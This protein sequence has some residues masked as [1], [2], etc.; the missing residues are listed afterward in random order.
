MI[1]VTMSW[2]TDN[3]Q[4]T[5]GFAEKMRII[6]KCDNGANQTMDHRRQATL[7]IIIGS[8]CLLIEECDN[9]D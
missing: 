4:W 2:T 5:T 1:N 9:D 7:P 3:R 8:S 6:C